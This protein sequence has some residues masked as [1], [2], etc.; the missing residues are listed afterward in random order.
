VAYFLLIG[1]V[2]ESMAEFLADNPRFADLAAQAGFAGLGSV[3]GYAATLFALLAIP[4]GAFTAV[5]IAATAAAETDRLLTLL[6][7]GP[8]T[9]RASSGAEVLAAAGGAVVLA[10]VA[11]LATWAG[12]AIVGAGLSL[13]GALAGSLNALSIVA[14]CLGAAVFALGLLP[15]AVALI[16]A[17]PAAGGFLLQVLAVDV[18]APEWVAKLSPFAHL[19]LVPYETPDWAGAAGM[20]AVALALCV[21]GIGAYERRDLRG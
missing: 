6:H 3:E 13:G 2:A 9:R 10:L 15:R 20:V 11:G 16:G 4:V 8:V 21:V 17:L 1:L 14:L 19:A 5:R 18:G 12:T 7:A